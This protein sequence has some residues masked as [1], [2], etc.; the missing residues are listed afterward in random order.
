M[1]SQQLAFLRRLLLAEQKSNVCLECTFE[2]FGIYTHFG[3]FSQS[4]RRRQA[5]EINLE[6]FVDA[7]TRIAREQA[8]RY[9][10]TTAC[11]SVTSFCCCFGCFEIMF[12]FVFFLLLFCLTELTRCVVR[13]RTSERERERERERE[14]NLWMC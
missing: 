7:R 8:G 12:Y 13:S 14:C 5:H 2:A 11:L 6:H 4:C 10:A 9:F 1:T 3:L